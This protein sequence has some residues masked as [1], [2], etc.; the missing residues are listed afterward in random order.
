MISVAGMK[1]FPQETEAILESHPSV[2]EAYVF[3]A[4]NN[5]LGEVPHARLVLK[6]RISSQPT[7]SELREH[8]KATL[9]YFKIPEEI[10]FVDKL[11]RTASGKL[12]RH[13]Q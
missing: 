3:P 13:F 4:S 2:K 12:I 11:P 8:C 5:R 1:F 6:K 9:S 7:V 10:E